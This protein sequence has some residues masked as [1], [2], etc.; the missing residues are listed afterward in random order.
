MFIHMYV[1]MYIH[2]SV[3]FSNLDFFIIIIVIVIIFLNIIVYECR[4]NRIN[5]RNFIP[6]VYSM[7]CYI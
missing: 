5:L 3:R 1:C 6:F 7:K 4:N 2:I